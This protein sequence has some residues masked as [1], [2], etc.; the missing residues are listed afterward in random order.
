MAQTINPNHPVYI[1]YSWKNANKPDLEDDVDRICQL[2]TEQGIY[3]KRDKD[4]L[5]PYRWN[6]NDAEKEIGEGSAILVVISEKYI[7][8]LHCMHEWHVIKENGKIWNRVFPII[9]PDAQI[10]NKEKYKEYHQYYLKRRNDLIS[11]QSEGIIPLSTAESEAAKFDYYINDLRDMYQYLCD[12]NTAK[13][14]VM[15]N[16]YEVII[17]QLK[18]HIKKMSGAQANSANSM[19]QDSASFGRAKTVAAFKQTS[20][21][22]TEP[23]LP[24]PPKSKM[25]LLIATGLIALLFLGWLIWWN[26]LTPFTIVEASVYHGD[27]NQKEITDTICSPVSQFIGLGLKIETIKEGDYDIHVKLFRN[28]EMISYPESPTGYSYSFRL[29][30]LTKDN[31]YYQGPEWGTSTPGTW[32]AGEYKAEIYYKDNLCYTRNFTVVPYPFIISNV[33]MSVT[34][35][36]GNTILDFGIPICEEITQFL[37]P[38]FHVKTYVEGRYDVYYKLYSPSGLSTGSSSV[39]GYSSKNTLNL[40]KNNTEYIGSGWGSTNKGNWKAGDYKVEYYYR[41]NL[42][43]TY[44]FTIYPHPFTIT[45]VEMANSDYNGTIITNYGDVIYSSVTQYLKPKLYI[46]P[47]SEGKFEIGVKLYS[48]DGFSKGK[49]TTSSYTY[50]DN[51]SLDRNTT[52][53]IL[54][55]WGS[56]KSGN[57]NAGDYKIEFYH[58]NEMLY[59][60]DFKVEK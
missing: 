48:P 54:T 58:N 10:T 55:G 8:S 35:S 45:K 27:G 49:T 52:Y 3:Y 46:T 60:H 50:T 16:N 28:D 56:T 4:N 21:A 15:Q 41:E 34:D 5:C 26:M 11:Q 14:V 12:T 24:A 51:M 23:S 29:E 19:P 25:P 18:E 39:G 40:D 44:N 17:S 1:S 20:V 37:T 2:M 13:S 31:E 57:W 47:I 7:K 22:V 43:Y 59:S 9:L 53:L 33:E 36:K 32:Q 30:N 42:I 6:I 38:K